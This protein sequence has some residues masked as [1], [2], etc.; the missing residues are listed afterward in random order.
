MSK[1]AQVTQ[2]R[3]NNQPSQFNLGGTHRV[4]RWPVCDSESEFLTLQ[5]KIYHDSTKHRKLL[6]FHAGL[7]YEVKRIH[8]S[9]NIDMTLLKLGLIC[10]VFAEELWLHLFFQLV[11][12]TY[13]YNNCNTRW[14]FVVVVYDH[15]ATWL[16]EVRN[17]LRNFHLHWNIIWKL[18]TPIPPLLR[19]QNPITWPFHGYKK[20]RKWYAVIPWSFGHFVPKI[21]F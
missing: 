2:A 4:R 1:C 20:N 10:I 18:I 19:S 6:C 12:R 13:K 16:D 11:L 21:G 5:N 3:H 15:L 14:I 8:K 17:P 7:A 9:C